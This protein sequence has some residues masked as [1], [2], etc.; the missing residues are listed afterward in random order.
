MYL[1][2]ADLFWAAIQALTSQ[3]ATRW[4]MVAEQRMVPLSADVFVPLLPKA[5]SLQ[6]KQS[7]SSPHQ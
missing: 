7:P 6:G 5:S 2:M 3:S 4:G 1:G